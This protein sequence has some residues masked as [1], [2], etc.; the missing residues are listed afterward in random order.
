MS[1][2]PFEENTVEFEQD[3]FEHELMQAMRRVDAPEGFADRVLAQIAESPA[4]GWNP[5]M[6]TVSEFEQELGQAMRPVDAPQGFADRV[7]A[8]IAADKRLR[9][10]VLMMPR[11]VRLWAGGAIAAALLAGAFGVREQRERRQ[12]EQAV[13]QARQQFRQA[14]QITGQT[15][16]DAPAQQQ[17]EV[18]MQI[19]NE[20]LASVRAQLQHT[21]IQLGD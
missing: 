4:H 1:V 16:A 12:Q 3:Q 10:K 14:M 8:Q 18:A 17:F 9:A 5:S 21:G 20:T 7:L 2:K 6:E 11:N 15:L 13:A 19:T